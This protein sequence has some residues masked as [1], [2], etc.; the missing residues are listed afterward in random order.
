MQENKWNPDISRFTGQE[1]KAITPYIPTALNM[2]SKVTVM[3]LRTGAILEA[4]QK[5]HDGG[6]DAIPEPKASGPMGNK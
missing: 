5:Y 4:I 3:L 6:K 2:I 1:V